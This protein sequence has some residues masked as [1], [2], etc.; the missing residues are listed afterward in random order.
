MLCKLGTLK[1]YKLNATDGEL[2]DVNGFYF[3]DQ[4][5]TVRYLV[6]DTGS[7]IS[8][9]Q[10]LISPY[11]VTRFIHN[12]KILSVNL[13]KRQIERSPGLETDKPVSM[14]FEEVYHAYYGWPMYW[15]GS[16]VWGNSTVMERDSKGLSL[17]AGEGKGWDR[18]LRSAREVTGYDIQA[19]DG[20]LGHVEDLL[21]DEETWSIRYLV[22]AT[23]NW[24][25]GKR[26]L[27]S[28][29]WIERVSWD[30]SKVFLNLTQEAIKK[31]PEFHEDRLL[32]RDYEVGLHLHYDRPGY[33]ERKRAA[34]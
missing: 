3:D 29:H 28:T 22:V 4:H 16:S 25:P 5:W 18:H 17:A 31:S 6:A 15:K 1:G 34:A 26:V 20:E 14:Q 30:G 21:V 23:K 8:G 9:R 12:G 33:W 2:G 13:T 10:V 27:V 24:W 11:A 7:W 19:L 32:T